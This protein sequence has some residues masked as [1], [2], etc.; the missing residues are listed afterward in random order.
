MSHSDHF[1]SSDFHRVGIFNYPKF[2]MNSAVDFPSAGADL[3]FFPASYPVFS[4]SSVSGG[5]ESTG[6][7]EREREK[8]SFAP[9]ERK[10]TV[11]LLCV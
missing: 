10:S 4:K 1:H 2:G 11:E 6:L 5:S 8:I 7:E 9:G 3:I